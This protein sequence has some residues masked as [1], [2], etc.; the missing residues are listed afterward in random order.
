MKKQKGFTIVE[1]VLLILFILG[2]YGYG[3]N[4]FKL[5]NC[6]F[7]SPYKCEAIHGMGL[8]PIFGVFTGYMDFSE[9]ENI[10]K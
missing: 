9:N 8:F 5:V 2:I 1:F 4:L 6:D 3:A 10:P 7:E